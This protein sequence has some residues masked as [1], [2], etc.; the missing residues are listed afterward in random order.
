MIAVYLGLGS[1]L[2][3]RSG[4]ISRAIRALNDSA[5]A[6]SGTSELYETSPVGF[7]HQPAFLNMVC[8]ANTDLSVSNLLKTIKGIEQSI[9]RT[10]S[11]TNGPREIDID[12]LFYGEQIIHTNSVS[13]PHPRLHERLF[14]LV[15]LAE[16]APSF[17]HPTLGKTISELII[18]ALGDQKVEHWEEFKH[19]T[20]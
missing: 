7:T 15:P 9:G 6:V 17:I 18:E 10:P 19:D 8:A 14:V 1:N 3:C 5:I 20:K 13:V 11:F 12:I 16:L 4:N 2:G